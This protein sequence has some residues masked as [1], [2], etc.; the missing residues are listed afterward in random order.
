MVETNPY[1]LGLTIVISV[2]HTVLGSLAIKNGKF[3]K[4]YVH[5]YTHTSGQTAFKTKYR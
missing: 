1:L 3:Y 4:T 5:D 2:V